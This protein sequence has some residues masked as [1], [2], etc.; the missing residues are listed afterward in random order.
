MKMLSELAYYAIMGIAV[1]AFFCLIL[2]WAINSELTLIQ[3]IIKY[4][5]LIVMEAVLVY[6]IGQV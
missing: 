6:A 1:F 5:Y 3:F 2:L 4:W